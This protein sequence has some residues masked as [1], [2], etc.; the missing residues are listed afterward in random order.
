MPVYLTIVGLGNG[1]GFGVSA[2]VSRM[3]GADDR[4]R[5][6][7]SAAWAA[8]LS[9]AFG[10]VLTLILVFGQ[11]GLVSVIGVD[12]I[13]ELA[14]TYM[15]PYS[16]CAVLIV[17]NGAV[18]GILNGQ[19][20]THYT[21]LLM[22]VQ[23]AVNMVLDPVFIYVLDMGLLGASVATVAATLVSAVIGN[24]LIVSGRTYL[25][26]RRKNIAYDGGCVR[27]LLT[28]GIPPMLEYTVMYFMDAVLNR[29]VLM[30]EAGSHALTVYSLPESLMNLIIV[31]AVAIGSA[32]IP[33]ASSAF[34]QRDMGRMRASFRFAI[35]RG[36]PIVVALAAIVEIFP[37]QI[38]YVFTYSEEMADIRPEIVEMLRVMC[39]YIG[40]F[41]FTPI[42]SGYL[43]A[44]GHPNRSL[45]VA[46]CR[47][48]VLTFF[49]WI[50]MQQQEVTSFGWALMFG[51]MI[52]ATT[53]LTVAF[54]TDRQVSK[55]MAPRIV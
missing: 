16:F 28:A 36:I 17:F 48:S 40:F 15:L 39:L 43:Q 55:T 33:V 11:E 34:G 18:A 3:I 4:G 7:M 24:I 46:V 14:C 49:F 25:P 1:F 5:A 29:L 54:F 32:L 23:A 21:M 12:N 50:A 31:P 45:I 27:M 51:H 38:L 9:L 20:A 37:E 44:L 22:V 35:T 30:T 53:I 2:V 13:S 8:I 52:G 42:C 19:G 41:A 47:N 10:L 6:S 26:I